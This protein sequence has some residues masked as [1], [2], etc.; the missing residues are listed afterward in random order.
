METNT[1]PASEA[2]EHWHSG[3]IMPKF[4]S[5]CAG[6]W[7]GMFLVIGAVGLSRSSTIGGV[8]L[9]MAALLII[10][11]SALVFGLANSAF[12]RFRVDEEGVWRRS[13][14]RDKHVPW[15]DVKQLRVWNTSALSGTVNVGVMF[16]LVGALLGLLFSSLAKR[17]E[18]KDPRPEDQIWEAR[19]VG[20]NGWTAMKIPRAYPYEFFCELRDQARAAGVTVL[21][22]PH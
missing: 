13:L 10:P 14:I 19:I 3:P 4:M 8:E 9:A 21:T 5:G 6:L 20:A 2:Q 7:L 11:C 16:G 1:P 17:F 22:T 15:T 12:T 18:R